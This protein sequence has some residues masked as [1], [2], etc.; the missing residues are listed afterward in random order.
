MT[1][2]SSAVSYQSCVQKCSCQDLLEYVFHCSY[3]CVSANS[4]V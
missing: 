2:V 3:V 1:V 4:A